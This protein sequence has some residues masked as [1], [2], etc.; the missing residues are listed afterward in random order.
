MFDFL[1]VELSEGSTFEQTR[2]VA[3][4]SLFNT[5]GILLE[6]EDIIDLEEKCR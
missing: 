2:N 1:R 3:D 6:V 4:L 5:A